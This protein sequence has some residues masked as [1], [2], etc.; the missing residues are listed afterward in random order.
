MRY[1]SHIVSSKASNVNMPDKAILYRPEDETITET[2][3]EDTKTQSEYVDLQ[4]DAFGKAI[5]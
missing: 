3:E 4:D 5:D 1:Y 2:I